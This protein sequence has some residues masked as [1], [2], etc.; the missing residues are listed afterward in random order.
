[1]KIG[2]TNIPVI[3]LKSG[4]NTS[5]TIYSFMP[6]IPLLDLTILHYLLN[7]SLENKKKAFLRIMGFFPV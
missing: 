7:F 1:M 3:H 2:V 6:F 5:I 4:K